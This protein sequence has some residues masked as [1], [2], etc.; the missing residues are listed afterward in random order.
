MAERAITSQAE[1]L[2]ARA[3]EAVCDGESWD[4]LIDSY[5]RL[6]GGDSGVI[7]VKNAA[8][9]DHSMVAS[10]GH[11]FSAAYLAKYLSYYEPRSPLIPFYRDSRTGSVRAL[12]DFAFSPAYRHSEFFTDWV[13]P[14]GFGDMIGGHLLRSRDLYC[15]LSIRRHDQRGPYSAGEVRLAGNVAPHLARAVRLKAKIEAERAVIPPGREF[16]DCM[17]CGVLFVDVAGKVL[18]LNRAAERLLSNHAGVRLNHGNIRCERPQEDALL[19]NALHSAARALSSAGN[20]AA[21]FVITR[22]DA[23]PLT[24]HVIPISAPSRWASLARSRA[25]AAIFLIDPDLETQR[26][27][28]VVVAAYGLTPAEGRLLRE[29]SNCRGLLEAAQNLNVTEA[30][31][32]THL[33]RIFSKTDTRNQIQLVSLL[34]KSSLP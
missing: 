5:V 29:I 4:D 33:Q 19:K 3:Y 31:A 15:W 10:S 12:G 17:S 32:R 8:A 7:F 20:S 26:R 30:T 11:D 25:V 16:I 22:R 18:G 6:V 2:I 27:V 13:R 21:D 28:N 34:A 14:Q 24:T 1:H 23:R 9:P